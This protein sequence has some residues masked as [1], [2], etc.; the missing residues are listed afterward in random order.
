MFYF[1]HLGTPYVIA[2]D[3]GLY[4]L[5]QLNGVLGRFFVNNS[6]PKNLI[7]FSGNDATQK[8]IVTFNYVG[9]QIDFTQANTIRTI[10]GFNSQLVPAAPSTVVGENYE[11]SVEAVFNRINFFYIRSTLVNNG[12]PINGVS[13]NIISQIPITAPPGSQI[14]YS[15]QNVIAIEARNLIGKTIQ[16]IRFELLDDQLRP[17]NTLSEYWSITLHIHSQL[18]LSTLTLPLIP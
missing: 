16:Q 4:S 18:L 3:T 15:P 5:A 11:S 14:N 17:V 7:V 13:G 6:L 1:S 12:L 8:T 10:L 9:T 2:I